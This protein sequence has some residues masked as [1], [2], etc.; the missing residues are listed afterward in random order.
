MKAPWKH[1]LA[2]VGIG[3][4]SHAVVVWAT[5]RVIMLGVLS[6]GGKRLGVNRFAHLPPPTADDRDIVRPCPDFAYSV[7]IL[8]LSKGPVRIRAPLTPPYTS[9]ALYSSTTDNTFVRSDRDTSAQVLDIVVALPGTTQSAVPSGSE[10][11]LARDARELA[12]V[13]R[14]VESPEQLPVIDAAQRQSICAPF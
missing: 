14:V 5:P 7:C 6:V 4:I 12:L 8:D 13:R 10:L 1:V 9:V 11:V 2:I 3:V